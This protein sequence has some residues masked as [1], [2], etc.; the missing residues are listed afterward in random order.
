MDGQISDVSRR[1]VLTVTV[2][3]TNYKQGK[4]IL[5]RGRGHVSYAPVLLCCPMSVQ[6]TSVQQHMCT[7]RTDEVRR[8]DQA[9]VAAETP[10]RS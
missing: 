8:G 2:L 3:G 4:L 6:H 9:T 5:L 10:H 1:L 7:G